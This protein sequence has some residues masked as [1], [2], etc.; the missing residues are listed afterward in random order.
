MPV[1]DFFSP[2]HPT[3]LLLDLIEI[4]SPC[5]TCVS[6][7]PRDPKLPE[8]KAVLYAHHV[9]QCMVQ[10]VAQKDIHEKMKEVRLPPHTWWVLPTALKVWFG[11]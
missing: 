6:A 1:D 10:G 9:W 2:P 3:T 8:V 5:P 4:F 11:K 7:S